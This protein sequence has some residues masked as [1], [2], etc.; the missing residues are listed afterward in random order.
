MNAAFLES[1][2]HVADHRLLER[3]RDRRCISADHFNPRGLELTPSNPGRRF[4]ANP[5]LRVLIS[6]MRHDGCGGRAGRAELLTGI[7]GVSSRPV[8][9]IVLLAG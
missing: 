5:L 3:A 1:G 8:R 4:F 6:R 9:R 7:D 2:Q